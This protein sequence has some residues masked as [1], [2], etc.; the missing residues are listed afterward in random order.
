MTE[1]LIRNEDG[2]YKIVRF[3]GRFKS[4][5]NYP[6]ASQTVNAFFYH[7]IEFNEEKEQSKILFKKE[8]GYIQENDLMH[9]V[10]EE[11]I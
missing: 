2:S 4:T 7:R 9:I 11:F 3:N 5:N 1:Y 10:P 6:T 8:Y